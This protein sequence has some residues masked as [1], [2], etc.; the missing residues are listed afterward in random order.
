MALSAIAL[1]SRALLKIGAATIASFDDGTAESEVAA[2]LYPAVRDALL[3][4]HPWN[5]ATGQVTLPRLAAQP[6]A[7]YAHA[8][9]LPADFLR[10]LSAGVSG[11]GFGLSYRIAES[12]LHCDSDEVV[13]TYVF[14]PDELSFPPF[15]DQALIARLAAE[16]CIPLTESTTRAEFLY[17]LSEDEFRR[18]KLI[19][20]QQD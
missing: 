20:G 14:R 7:D 2:N 9:Q 19:D 3:S 8:F 12:R 1:C 10:A 16:F 17:R 4:S 13:L 6:V 11:R 15:F 18:A 5:F